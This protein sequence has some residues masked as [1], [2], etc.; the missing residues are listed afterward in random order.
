[1]DINFA[2]KKYLPFI[3]PCLLFLSSCN[4]KD[5]EENYNYGHYSFDPE[6]IEKIPSYDS[7]VIAIIHNYPALQQ[8]INMESSYKAFRYMPASDDKEIFNRLPAGTGPDIDHYYKKLGKGFIDGFDLFK[9]SSIK[10]YVRNRP[11]DSTSLNV[12]ENLSYYPSGKNYKKR[13]F[14]ARDT[15]L[16][17]HWQYWVN[18]YKPALF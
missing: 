8:H 5:P 3:L 18:F 13:E 14:P 9:D 10:I 16:S 11:S 6:V 1:M 12:E 7:L 2:M 15:I 4:E 17:K